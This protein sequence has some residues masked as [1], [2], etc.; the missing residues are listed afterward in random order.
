MVDNWK[1]G[2]Y[3]SLHNT[4]ILGEDRKYGVFIINVCETCF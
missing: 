4:M 1:A 3:S 2:E